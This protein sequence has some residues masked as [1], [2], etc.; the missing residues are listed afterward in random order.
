MWMLHVEGQHKS[1][2]R[3]SAPRDLQD[4]TTDVKVVLSGLWIAMLFVFAYVD[5]FAFWRADVIDGA[6]AGTVPGVGF[7]I[8][9]AF[10]L[11][12]TA[13]IVIPSLM[14]VV[15]LIAPAR[16]NRVA[17]LIVSCS[18]A[19]TIIVACLGETWWYF[20]AGST[21][22]L[23]LLGYLATKAWNWPAVRSL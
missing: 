11:A 22:E 4:T 12:T 21:V 13:Y 8:D 1:M 20:L 17:N 15:S 16:A 18:Y 2:K 3:K 19:A 10:L 6:L 23:A 14:V 7:A 9:Q 5:I